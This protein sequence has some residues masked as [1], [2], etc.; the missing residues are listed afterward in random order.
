MIEFLVIQIKLGKLT[1]D[2]VPKKYKDEVEKELSK[3]V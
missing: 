2:K 1:L 3:E